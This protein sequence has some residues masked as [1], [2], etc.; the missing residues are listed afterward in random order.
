MHNALV[1]IP[2]I[3]QLEF[4][5]TRFAR[6]RLLV[7]VASHYVA[8]Q[9]TFLTERL[10]HAPWNTACEFLLDTMVVIFNVISQASS[11]PVGLATLVELT[12]KSSLAKEARQFCGDYLD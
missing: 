8:C 7:T 12:P 4:L 2:N 6:V 1:C 5:P 3:A 10:R 11:I 9:P